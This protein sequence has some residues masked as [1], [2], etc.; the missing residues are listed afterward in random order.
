MKLNK[1]LRSLLLIVTLFVGQQLLARDVA[2][3]FKIY[4][5]KCSY[6]KS[7]IK[8]VIKE[9]GGKHINYSFKTQ[10]VEFEFDNEETDIQDIHKKIAEA[11]FKTLAAKPSDHAFKML[12]VCAQYNRA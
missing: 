6:S 12:P 1:L 5:G 2:V 3:R 7:T 8:K 9:M 4:A 11:G 10:M